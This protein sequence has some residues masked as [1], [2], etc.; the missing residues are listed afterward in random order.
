MKRAV[1]G[2]DSGTSTRD[3]RG[4]ASTSEFTAAVIKAITAGAG[5]D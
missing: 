2:A 4:S 3:L 5:Q 1:L